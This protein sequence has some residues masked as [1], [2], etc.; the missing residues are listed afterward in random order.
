MYD[1]VKQLVLESDAYA[2]IKLYVDQNNQRAQEV[3]RQVGMETSHYKLFEW[4]KLD[5]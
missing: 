1:H 2:G 5:Y 4:N 3:Y